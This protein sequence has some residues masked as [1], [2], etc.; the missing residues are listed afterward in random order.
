M[1]AW[2]NT[3]AQRFAPVVPSDATVYSP[4]F[5]RLFVGGAGTV[6][7]VGQDGV[8]ATFTVG[9]GVDLNVSGSKVMAT[10]T[11]ATLIVAMY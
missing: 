4:A 9:A 3:P 5:R 11:T 1:P 10:G 8:S 2:E 6:T 7:V